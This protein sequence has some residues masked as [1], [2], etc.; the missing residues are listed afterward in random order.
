MGMRDEYL[1]SRIPDRFDIDDAERPT[2]S[3]NI[4][5]AFYH[6]DHPG[7]SGLP[8]SYAEAFWN[9]SEINLIAGVDRDKSR[10]QAFAERYSIQQLYTDAVEML[11]Q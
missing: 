9:R 6:H 10:L 3:L 8:T 11:S 1:A 5:L 4:H 7:D 2:P